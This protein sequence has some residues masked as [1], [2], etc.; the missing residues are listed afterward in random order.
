MS[1]PR[2]ALRLALVMIV[3]LGA[4]LAVLPHSTERTMDP[5]S[6]HLMNV[7]RCFER[8]QGFSNPAA[9]PAWMRPERLPMPET[10]KEPAYSW[11]IAQLAAPMG[12]EFPAGVLISFLAGLALVAVSYALARN[13]GAGEGESTLAALLVA[14]NPLAVS[15]SVR[16][17]V[18]GLFP[19]LLLACFALAAWRRDDPGRPWWIDVAT[20][21]AAGLAFM[22]R[23][24]TLVAVPAIALLM[25]HRPRAHAVRGAAIAAV[26]AVVTASPFLLRNLRLFGVPFYSD[27]GQF[28]LWPYVDALQ[29][30]HGLERPAS[31][32]AWALAHPAPV[33]VHWLQSVVRFARHT[34]PESVVGNPVWLPACAVGALLILAAWRRFAGPI[35][36]VACTCTLVFAVIWDER[37]FTSFVPLFAIVTALGALW[38]ARPL[39]GLPVAGPVRGRH[40][41]VLVVVLA[42]MTQ[43]VTTWHDEGRSPPTELEAARSLGPFLHRSLAP[44]EA[45]M[46]VTTS[47]YSWFADRP[48]VH[49]V[50]ADEARFL[51]VIRRLKVRWAALPTTR[52][53]E[54]AARFPGRRLPSVLVPVSHDPV[55]DVTLFRVLDSGR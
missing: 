43:V 37:Y 19:A 42:S 6:A 31:P 2:T 35:V 33:F 10:F 20:G 9:W 25:P 36:Y 24:Q 55:R 41:F 50:I 1:P 23:G 21:V 14:V 30:S 49:F 5:D 53:P 29:F 26:A 16:V 48:S 47:Y 44:D 7:A 40:V 46:A 28:G 3:A 4:R 45:V 22:T 39:A 12:G 34:L 27:V 32:L 18:D 17:M 51:E 13:L 15:M 52:V 54:F 38:I 8:G 11:T